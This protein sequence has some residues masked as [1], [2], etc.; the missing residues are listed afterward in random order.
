MTDD[1]GFRR[2]VNIRVG[3]EDWPLLQSVAREHGGIQAGLLAAL[4]SHVARQLQPE[5]QPASAESAD[6]DAANAPK[7]SRTAPAPKPARLPKRAPAPSAT[8]E[9]DEVELNVAE[10]APVLGLRAERLR[11]EIKRGVRPGRRS[12]RGFYL[13]RLPK[14]LLRDSGAE[15]SLR[16]AGE[17]LG[18]K[19]GTVRGRCRQGR[20][21]NAR[22]TS[23]GWRVPASDLL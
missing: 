1:K 21:P 20:Y 5:Q 15:L 12:E 7:P 8:S 18:L 9:H 19:A 4:R 2:Q 3:P 23:A 22:H 10:A 17:L 16:G 14:P 6:P 11:E 13:A